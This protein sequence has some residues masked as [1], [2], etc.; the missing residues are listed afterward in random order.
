[1]SEEETAQTL[2]H[3]MGELHLEIIVDRLLR[4]F[5]VEANVGKPQ[6]AFRETIRRKGE[7]QGRYVR[8]TGGR[9]Q[10]G[11]VYIEVEPNEPGG[12][13]RAAPGAAQVVRA[14][15]PLATVC[16]YATEMRSMTEGRATYTMQSSR[17]EEVPTAIAE[18]IMAKVAGKPAAR[19]GTR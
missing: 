8:Q 3:G 2:I 14:N 17:Y 12:G 7:A 16:G 9:G 18:E 4:E 15:V 1:T 6:V 11:D 13:F 5:R 10:Y 19:A